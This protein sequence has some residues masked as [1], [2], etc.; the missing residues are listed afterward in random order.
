[1]VGRGAGT[2][3]QYWLEHRSSRFTVQDAHSL[4]LETLAELGIAGLAF[5]V[6][7]FAVPI[8]GGVY[9]RSEPLAAASLGGL[10]VY[11][12]HASIE[13]D[14]ELP[15]VTVAAI[16]VAAGLVTTAD[17]ASEGRALSPAFR[18]V[19]VGAALAASVFAAF[20]LVGNGST[21]EA[22]RAAPT[23]VRSAN[24][25]SPGPGDSTRGPRSAVQPREKQTFSTPDS[26]RA[27][28]EP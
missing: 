4:Y 24:V 9:R 23:A 27:T 8:A 14:W 13:W 12:A 22:D 7:L 15:A 16:L 25:P 21:V 17:G 2:F 26:S 6:V 5:L 19:A 28:V 18:T 3:G 10:A 11:L 1:V 20:G